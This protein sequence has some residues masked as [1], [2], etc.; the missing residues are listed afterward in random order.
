MSRRLL[1]LG[2]GGDL[3]ARLLLPALAGLQASGRLPDDLDLVGV[4]RHDTSDDAF[5]SEAQAELAEHA[6]DVDADV[7]QALVRRFTHRRADATEP[8][9]VRALV[10]GGPPAIVYLAL[11][12]ALFEPTIEALAAC[13]LPDGSRI[14]VEKPFGDSLEAARR[15]NRL[16]E[17]FDDEMVFRVDHFLSLPAVRALPG[18]RF[19]N[20]LLEPAWSGE[21][22]ERIEVTWDEE[23][24]L[25]GRAGYYDGAGALRDMLQNHLLATLSVAIMDRPDGHDVAGVRSAR[26]EVLRSLRPPAA[27][28]MAAETRRARYGAGDGRPAYEDEAGVDPDRKTET[29][30]EVILKS[31]APRWRGVPFV[32]RSAKAIRTERSEL[33]VRF[34]PPAGGDRSPDAAAE[35]L[36]LDLEAAELSLRL[37]GETGASGERFSV[38]GSVQTVDLRAYESVLISLLDGNQGPFV[39][40]EEAEEAWR[41]MEP[42]LDAWADDHVPLEEYPAGSDGLA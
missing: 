8:D 34:R 11:P 31:D 10:S 9:E 21:H 17:R 32:L 37:V 13:D 38:E 16:L 24:G 39:G 14:A 33:V 40:P 2:A 23:L 15:L 12:P 6:S 7:R 35:R 27:D 26:L 22:I 36:R 41:I 3:F 4:T 29:L 19:A 25:E 28:A 30:A 1:V 20:R 42:V 18:L 5:R